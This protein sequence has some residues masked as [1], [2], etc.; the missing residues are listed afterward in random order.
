MNWITAVNIPLTAYYF[1]IGLILPSA[2]C[3]PSGRF[4]FPTSGLYAFIVV[5]V[6][7]IPSLIIHAWSSYLNGRKCLVKGTKS[8]LSVTVNLSD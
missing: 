2:P 5:N 1:G 8:S 7:E 4:G 3:F 6:R